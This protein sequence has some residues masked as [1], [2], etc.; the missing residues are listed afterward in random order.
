MGAPPMCRWMAVPAALSTDGLVTEGGDVA[1]TG[2]KLSA[3]SVEI[4]VST[5][6]SPAVDR[7]S[8]LRET[9]R[10]RGGGGLPQPSP[11]FM[12]TPLPYG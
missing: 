11:G 10:A 8:G 5:P 7:D 6:Q 12:V 4:L 3:A 1:V 2:Q 9:V